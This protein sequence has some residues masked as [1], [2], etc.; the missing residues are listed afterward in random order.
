MKNN[1]TESAVFDGIRKTINRFREKPFHYFTEADIHSSL[2]NDITRAAPRL[3][4]FRPDKDRGKLKHLNHISI[5]L[6]HQ[7]YPTNFRYKK[8]MLLQGYDSGDLDLTKL[9]YTNHEGKGYGDR[10]NFD[11]AVLKKRFVLDMLEKHELPNAL[12]QIINKDNE[13]AKERLKI[14]SQAFEKELLYAIEVKFIH[15]FNARNIKMLHEV[16]KDD[17][18]L[19]L[20]SKNSQ[21]F[22]K[23]INLV[24]CSTPAKKSIGGITSVVD[25]IKEYVKNGK[26]VDRKGLSFEHPEQVIT[27]FVESF[28]GKQNHKSTRPP[29]AVYPNKD[30]A[31]QLV[32]V[33]NV[34]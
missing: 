7:E 8:E 33:L 29:I 15:S 34:K 10:G 23:P 27:I 24:F 26:V 17:Q 12:E 9:D 22:V 32:K 14:S 6:V 20:A 21:G 25:L 28:I 30:W 31:K 2:L 13:L 4:I 3:M 11:L 1:E 5:S 19:L 16:I 18:K